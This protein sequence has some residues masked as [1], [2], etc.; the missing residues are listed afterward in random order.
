[1]RFDANDVLAGLGV[2]LIGAGLAMISWPLALGVVGGLLFVL[3]MLRA[4]AQA[5]G[6]SR[7]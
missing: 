7:K 6:A 4:W 3:G 2:L 1:M 5:Q